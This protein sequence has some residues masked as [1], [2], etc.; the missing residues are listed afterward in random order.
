MPMLD[1]SRVIFGAALIGMRMLRGLLWL[2][3][4]AVG[5]CAVSAAWAQTRTIVSLG[6]TSARRL[7]LPALP[8]AIGVPVVWVPAEYHP[9][10]DRSHGGA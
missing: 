3:V 1:P 10:H 6:D 4:I 5:S 2:L 9:L 7:A 8:T